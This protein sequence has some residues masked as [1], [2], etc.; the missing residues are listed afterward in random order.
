MR[1]YILNLVKATRSYPTLALGASPRGSLALFRTA[2]ACAA[3]NGRDFVLPDDVKSMAIACLA[4]RIIVNPENV[5]EGK[6]S[7]TTVQELLR[8]VEVPIAAGKL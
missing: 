5:L 8:Q 3:L 2:Q 1:R 4:H 6:T 7:I